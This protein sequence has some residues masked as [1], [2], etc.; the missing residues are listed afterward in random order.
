VGQALGQLL[1]LA[2][3]VA[4]SPVPI[5]AVILM[6][7]SARASSNGP[8]FLL[9][10]VI[11]IGA[12]VAIALVSADAAS[13]STESDASNASSWVKLAFGVLL[14]LGGVRQWRARPATG[15]EPPMP[16]WMRGIDT[17]T[18][19]KALGLA[20]LLGAL[21]PKNVLLGAAAGTTIAQADVSGSERWGAWLIFVILGSL[22]VAI[23]VLYYLAG[24][25]G[26]QRTLDS[27]KT[28]LQQNNAA[29]MAVL[30]LVLGVVLV[31]QSIQTL[32]A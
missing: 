18:A 11:G 32:S 20:S 6:L 26:A 24:G 12:V 25:E 1:P 4:L 27:W 10:W 13:V 14:A 30:L 9:G 19:P 29:V 7:F 2:I 8:A 3:G 17:F 22:T 5:I 16:K 23:P 28:W 31:G 15:E 21:N